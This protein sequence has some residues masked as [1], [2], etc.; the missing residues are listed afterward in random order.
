MRGRDAHGG[1]IILL[2]E[3]GHYLLRLFL[4]DARKSEYLTPDEFSAAHEK[5]LHRRLIFVGGES[6]DILIAL[7]LG[8]HLL[9]GDDLLHGLYL[10]AYPG[11]FFIL[12]K[13]GGQLHL[14]VEMQFKRPLLAFQEENE[15][16]DY[17]HI[18]GAGYLAGTGRHAVA[19]IV[20]QAGTA[21]VAVQ[22]AFAAAERKKGFHHVQRVA[23]GT[24]IGERAEIARAVGGDITHY[25]NARPVLGQI[26]LEVG[27]AP[28]RP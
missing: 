2:H 12:Q 11:G 4:A 24:G 13:F 26:Y 20:F 10:V 9:P 19:H 23:D 18:L 5:H 22:F 16:V 25:L 15:F 27:K 14:L 1:G 8:G 28:C 7:H 21:R 6:D 3:I 17:L